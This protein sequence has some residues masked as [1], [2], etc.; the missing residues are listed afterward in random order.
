[1]ERRLLAGSACMRTDELAK[2]LAT[3]GPSGVVLP[4]VLRLFAPTSLDRGGEAD[5]A[6]RPKPLRPGRT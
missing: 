6:S 3:P 4:A 2:S 5:R 1:M